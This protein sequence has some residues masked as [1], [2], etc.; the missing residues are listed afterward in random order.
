MS[1]WRTYSESFH[2]R[3]VGRA[4]GATKPSS[5]RNMPCFFLVLDARAPN[6]AA[7]QASKGEKHQQTLN[8]TAHTSQ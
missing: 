1:T 4:K 6:A 5:D 8:R 3:V 2:G 7:C